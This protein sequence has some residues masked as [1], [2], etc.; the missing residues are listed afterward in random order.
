MKAHECRP[1]H[2][3]QTEADECPN[4]PAPRVVAECWTCLAALP[5]RFIDGEEVSEPETTP[6]SFDRASEAAR[7]RAAGHDVRPVEVS[8]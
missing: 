2:H 6:L 3:T 1:N 4:Q 7:H 8:K 5:S